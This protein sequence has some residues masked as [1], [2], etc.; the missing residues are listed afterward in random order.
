MQYNKTKNGFKITVKDWSSEI[1]ITN[2]Q[3][4]TIVKRATFSDHIKA[5]MLAEKL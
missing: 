4:G 3:T 2:A 5:V 1:V